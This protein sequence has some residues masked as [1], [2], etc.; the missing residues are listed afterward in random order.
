MSFRNDHNTPA[1][2]G[3]DSRHDHM[4]LYLGDLF[5][6]LGGTYMCVPAK[7]GGGH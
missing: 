1:G 5:N 6:A 2:H 7:G 3:I 4:Q